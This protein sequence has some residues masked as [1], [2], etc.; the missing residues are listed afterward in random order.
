MKYALKKNI[1]PY[2][3]LI[4]LV[5][6]ILL[7]YNK[8]F[9]IQGAYPLINPNFRELNNSNRINNLN[10]T[11]LGFSHIYVINLEYRIDRYR[12]MKVLGNYLHLNLDIIKAVN[13]YDRVAISKL[14]KSGLSA[15]VKACYLSHYSIFE[16]IVKNGYE[17]G[18]IFEDDI[19]IEI[20]ITNIMTEVYRKLPSDWDMLY[21]GHCSERGSYIETGLTIHVLY[22]SEHPKCTHA[23]AV[24]AKGAKKLLEK[25]NIIDPYYHLDMQIVDLI[26][27][28]EIISYSIH[29]P[30]VVQFKGV[31]DLSDV[32]PGIEGGTDPLM[33][34]TLRILGY[35]PDGPNS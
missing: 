33:N 16:S 23:Y 15:G 6:V 1:W 32:S 25:L 3:G 8:T 5:L 21:L 17:N 20:N 34:S 22:K 12:K 4:F 7:I 11:T 35:D 27:A 19:D 14:N 30:I 26:M 29:P 24:S 2:F 18:L 13:K 31:T 28:G 9:L 10:C